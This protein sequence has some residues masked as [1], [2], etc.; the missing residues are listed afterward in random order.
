EEAQ[1]QQLQNSSNPLDRI[2]GISNR[3]GNF[4]EGLS[5]TGDFLG[6]KFSS[7]GKLTNG[8]QKVGNALQTGA[9]AVKNVI[10]T[11]SGL[12]NTIGSKIGSAVGSGAATG[13]ATSAGATAGAT[14]GTTA[15]TTT[16]ANA[17][18]GA[19][20]GSAASGAAAAGPIGALVA[21]GVMALQGTNR[22]RAKQSGQQAQQL[23]Q[24]QVDIAK[25]RLTQTS[26]IAEQLGNQ[27]MPQ[28]NLN[29][30]MQDNYLTQFGG[31][32]QSLIDSY[33]Q[34]NMPEGDVLENAIN[35]YVNNPAPVA[36]NPQTDEQT[37]QGIFNKLANGLSDFMT[38]YK[39]NRENGFNPNNLLPEENKGFMQRV[40]E[41]F[42]TTARMIHNP[43]AQGL[44]AGGLSTALTG[45]PLYGLGMAN[46]FANNKMN[47]DLYQ[48]ILKN[49]GVN[50]DNYNGV[51]TSD[52]MSKILTAN[53]YQKG[54]MTRKDYDRLRLEN[55]LITV[56]EYNQ[57]LSA[58]D[59]NPDEMVN[60]TG[61][62]T[63][64]KAGRNMQ[65]N[66]NDKSKNY[67]R[68]KNEGKNVIK[69]EY[70]KKPDS[71]NY[72]HVTYG[73]KP[74]QKSTTYVTYDAKPQKNN[75]GGKKDNSPRIKV[76]SPDG[77]VGSIPASQLADAI[78]QGF[79]KL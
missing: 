8:M 71:H 72:T 79:K 23:A 67:Y 37:K 53:K 42:G 33:I 36:D 4:G 61:L 58:P 39:E 26:Q 1:T 17:G 74:E 5:N 25:D 6:N 14:A 52:D 68:S 35:S 65:E 44:V 31:D 27:S 40:G 41:G 20:G 16:G 10:P 47:S 45:N 50:F 59:Y 56:D 76:K 77:K 51:I 3:V 57:S 28:N 69:V 66:K 62:E 49:Q 55:G 60:I 46:K 11:S 43:I 75:S 30:N 9:N 70:G 63:V 7:M 34:S 2:N 24:T 13:A 18:A 48:Q 38:G 22:K 12:M 19:A 64:S 73:A 78:K 15:A 29:Q 21:L 32:T 54:F